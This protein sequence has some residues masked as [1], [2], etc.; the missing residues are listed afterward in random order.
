[1]LEVLEESSL[2]EGRWSFSKPH[3]RIAELVE[4]SRSRADK[5]IRRDVFQI[6]NQIV[7]KHASPTA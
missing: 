7:S 5:L 1:M 3:I 6:M 2:R 4:N